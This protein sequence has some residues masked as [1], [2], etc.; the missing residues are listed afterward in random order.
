[1]GLCPCCCL[2]SKA[3]LSVETFPCRQSRLVQRAAL[4]SKCEITVEASARGGEVSS[5][6]IMYI[7]LLV[8]LLV[9]SSGSGD[10]SKRFQNG[11]VLAR[12][13]ARDAYL[14]QDLLCLAAVSLRHDAA[15]GLSR[16]QGGSRR[17]VA[18]VTPA[19]LPFG[20][21][22]SASPNIALFLVPRLILSIFSIFPHERGCRFGQLTEK[23]NSEQALM[24][25]SRSEAPPLAH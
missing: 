13:C 18:V 1:M 16:N 2:E 25:T 15:K 11:L 7:V 23:A 3:G 22:A 9:L 14:L 8:T 5:R 21:R 6:E 10:L 24:R 4:Y 20:H 17:N 19:N 12:A